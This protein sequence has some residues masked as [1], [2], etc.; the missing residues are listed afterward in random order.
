MTT[1]RREYEMV[2]HKLNRMKINHLPIKILLFKLNSKERTEIKHKILAFAI[3]QEDN[4][5]SD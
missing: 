2:I 3:N 1:V 4:Q 5:P